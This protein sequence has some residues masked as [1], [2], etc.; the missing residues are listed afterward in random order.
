MSLP[1]QIATTVKT[2]SQT[3]ATL[4]KAGIGI[5]Q[6]GA[7]GLDITIGAQQIFRTGAGTHFGISVTYVRLP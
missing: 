4:A 1:G 6:L 7:R 3:L 5:Q 2:K